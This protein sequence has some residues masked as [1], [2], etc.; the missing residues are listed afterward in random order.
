MNDKMIQ[1][2]REKYPELE[3]DVERFRENP[4]LVVY[5]LDTLVAMGPLEHLEGDEQS[6]VEQEDGSSTEGDVEMMER[7]R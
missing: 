5:L 7:G 2:C 1:A 3:A 6:L 4:G